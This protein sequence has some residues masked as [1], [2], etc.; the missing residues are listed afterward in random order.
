MGCTPPHRRMSLRSDTPTVDNRAQAVL[1]GPGLPAGA[2]RLRRTRVPDHSARV[3]VR[4]RRPQ[5]A[6]GSDQ[7]RAGVEAAQRPAVG[8]AAHRQGL[9]AGARRADLDAGWARPAGDPVHGG[10]AAVDRGAAGAPRQWPGAPGPGPHARDLVHPGGG[11]DAAC[12]VV[13]PRAGHPGGVPAPAR[14]AAAGRDHRVRAGRVTDHHLCHQL[15]AALRQPAGQR[16]PRSP[17]PAGA[18]TLPVRPRS[19][20]S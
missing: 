7:F 16:M 18:L 15:R 2:A 5:C 17:A 11:R 3:R 9:G 14:P 1:V 4:G 8:T 10:V 6:G 12:R 13:E 19:C 20:R